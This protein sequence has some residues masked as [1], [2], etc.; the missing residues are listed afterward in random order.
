MVRIK[1]VDAEIGLIALI[2][3]TIRVDR[4][5]L[6][7]PEVLIET[8]RQ[9]RGNWVFDRR[10]PTPVPAAPDAGKPPL[11]LDVRR[12]R[13]ANGRVIFRNGANGHEQR[14]DLVQMNIRSRTAEDPLS[15]DLA[16]TLDGRPFTLV[17]S[18]GSLIGLSGRQ[19]PLP[20]E[21]KV[22]M[23]DARATLT[24]A[25][26]QPLELAGIDVRVA[27][28]GDELAGVMR[29]FDIDTPALG[30]YRLSGRLTGSAR[31]LGA[32]DVVVVVGDPGHTGVRLQGAIRDVPGFAGA[33]F[34]VS[35][36]IAD[37]KQ[38]GYF[39]RQTALTLP[40]IGL[41]A[42]VTQ[43]RDGY[44]IR[45][46]AVSL[47]NSSLSG[48]AAIVPR[49][50]RWKFTAQLAGPL[51]D[52][53][54]L[55]P[56]LGP[57]AGTQPPPKQG[58]RL[59]SDAPLSIDWLGAIDLDL[60]LRAD[61]LALAATPELYAV[62]AHVVLADGRFSLDRLLLKLSPEGNALSA[63]LQLRTTPT[64]KLD[65]NASAQ[66]A[67]IELAHLLALAHRASGISGALTDVTFEAHAT[68]GSLHE[69][70]AGL[71]G[72]ARFVVGPGQVDERTL[73]RGADLLTRF[74]TLVYPFAQE[75]SHT[76]LKCAVVRLPARAGIITVNRSIALETEKV[77]IVA[78]GIID[79]RRETIELHARTQARKGL[80]LGTG[81]LTNM[82][83][84]QGA[85]A[86]PSVAISGKGAL[87]SG[88]STGAAVGTAG[89]SLLVERLLLT[90]RQPCRTALGPPP[91]AN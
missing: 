66:G 17:G 36:R 82:Y 64:G 39:A 59:F 77:S 50:P 29:Y 6:V 61:R 73:D 8:N 44:V 15:I 25:M 90:D 68:G 19:Q 57:G 10:R 85:L 45:D 79:L 7:Q 54:E 88:L 34:S 4:F 74:F 83:Q 63:R 75:K 70:M 51:I 80:G 28:E 91:E 16:A 27:A 60:K 2:A 43:S 47:G 89:V 33:D 52:V 86:A 18:L 72:E 9:G 31:L 65:V 26:A 24:G 32:S 20:M 30:R 48:T 1:R 62:N 76:T 22:R 56:R 14:L 38:H 35:A 42:R 21:F 23:G 5:N 40:P 49:E 58:E 84:I 46:I 53:R 12:L 78:S 11:A 3:G 55:L 41:Q 87:G 37:P 71:N 81:K 69:L 67:A 13:V